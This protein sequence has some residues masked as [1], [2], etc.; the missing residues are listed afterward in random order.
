MKSFVHGLFTILLFALALSACKDEK[1]SIPGREYKGLLFGKEYS[2][3]VV[4]DSTDY[5]SQIDSIIRLFE[6]NF[7]LLDS[8][9]VISKINAHKETDQSFKF[10]D[11]TMLFGIVFDI[12]RDYNRNSQQFFDPTMNPLKREWFKIKFAGLEGEP[13]LD[14]L[15]EFVAFDGA[16]IDL[17]E[18][19]NEKNQYTHTLVRKKDPRV[20]IDFTN[21]ASAYACDM[22]GDFFTEK[23]ISQFRIKYQKSII[24]KGIGVDELNI[25]PLGI[26]GD[27]LDNS[28]RLI[29]GAFSLVRVEDKAQ[30]VDPT[31]GYPVD[32]E[33]VYVA[34]AAKSLSAAVVYSEVFMIMGFDQ[35]SRWYEQNEDSGVHSFMLIQRGKE[36]T[37]ASTVGFDE[38]LI[39]PDN[40]TETP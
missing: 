5:T 12:V 32:N 39:V 36:I 35:S 40:A 13:N 3:D 19:N 24:C 10:I 30:L 1:K 37:S 29:N 25:V 22:I 17:I 28:I 15:Y 7:S 34:V 27:S 26:T 23:G 21:I 31:Y 33:V 38:M 6:K 14:S 4:S 18:I 9:S 11:S 16:K 2:I 8:S 20:E